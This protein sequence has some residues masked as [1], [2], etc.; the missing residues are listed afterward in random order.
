[1]QPSEISKTLLNG[2]VGQH[3]FTYLSYL[4]YSLSPPA[5]E[6]PYGAKM[7]N[8]PTFLS[9]L[10]KFLVQAATHHRRT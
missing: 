8:P 5:P 6:G 1:M 2:Q 3:S 10:A 9:M 4:L 7:K